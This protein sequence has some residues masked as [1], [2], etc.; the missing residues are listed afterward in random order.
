MAAVA[1]RRLPANQGP[2]AAA[3]VAMD[4]TGLELVDGIKAKQVILTQL[5]Q[6]LEVDYFTEPPQTAF[7]LGKRTVKAYRWNGGSSRY[8]ASPTW[9]STR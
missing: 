1:G 7:S 6:A 5:A 3:P 8:C 4:D 9:T 2:T